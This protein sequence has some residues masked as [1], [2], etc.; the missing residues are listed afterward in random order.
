MSFKFTINAYAGLP[1]RYVIV[2]NLSGVINTFSTAE[3]QPDTGI[4]CGLQAQR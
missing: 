1:A 3:L 4:S 2:N